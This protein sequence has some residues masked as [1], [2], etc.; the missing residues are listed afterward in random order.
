MIED[1]SGYPAAQ[2]SALNGT[3]VLC[4]LPVSVP[5]E[6]LYSANSTSHSANCDKGCH[7]EP[8]SEVKA[9][10]G[11]APMETIWTI[12]DT[13]PGARLSSGRHTGLYIMNVQHHLNES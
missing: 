13:M 9:G 5:S 6:E 8:T 1:S 3:A 4:S 12:W 11:Q 2:Q 7:H 10:F